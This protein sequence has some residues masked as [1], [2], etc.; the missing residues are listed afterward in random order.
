MKTKKIL[1]GT[2]TGTVAL[3][4]IGWGIYG[5]ALG[6]YMDAH[7][8]NPAARPMDQMVM[9]AMVLSNFMAALLLTLIIDWSG[10]N[11]A[12]GGARVGV[13]VGALSALSYDL[14]AYSMSTMFLGMSVIAVDAIAYAVMLGIGG[15]IVGFAMQKAGAPDVAAAS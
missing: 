15:A 10:N 1:V 12:M 13:I 6:D 9:W 3:F 2:L 11:S 4:F 7:M 14:S 5:A 8:N